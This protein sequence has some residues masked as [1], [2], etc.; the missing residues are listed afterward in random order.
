MADSEIHYF[1]GWLARGL[2]TGKKGIATSEKMYDPKYPLA[3][4][5]WPH[6]VA[7]QVRDMSSHILE[8]FMMFFL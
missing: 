7:I 2:S 1:I 5:Q 8:L 4:F 3:S 6:R